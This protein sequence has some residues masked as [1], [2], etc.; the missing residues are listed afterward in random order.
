[1][2]NSGFNK[3]FKWTDENIQTA[4][5]EMAHQKAKVDQKWGYIF[6]TQERIESLID[7]VKSND[8]VQGS[9][10]VEILE[11]WKQGKYEKVDG[12]TIRFGNY[13]VGI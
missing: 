12:I 6:I 1:M 4:L 8:L 2:P 7:I 13:K 5:H 10:Y 3:N 11:R 9:T